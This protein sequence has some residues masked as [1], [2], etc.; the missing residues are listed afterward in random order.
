[1]NFF[2]LPYIQKQIRSK[3]KEHC[4][5]VVQHKTSCKNAKNK[6]IWKSLEFL[7]QTTGN[8]AEA[9]IVI[10]F[11]VIG[12]YNVLWILAMVPYDSRTNSRCNLVGFFG[13]RALIAAHVIP[14]L[15]DDDDD[16]GN[17][18]DDNDNITGWI[19]AGWLIFEFISPMF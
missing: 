10:W 12:I 13:S 15:V 3:T 7:A 5:R 1:M 17:D 19:S 9:G 4:T 18:D 16:S 6:R 14:L 8:F 11:S 2:Q